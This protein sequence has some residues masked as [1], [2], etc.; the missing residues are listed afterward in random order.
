MRSIRVIACRLA[1]AVLLFATACSTDEGVGFNVKA[2]S[3]TG[4]FVS[5]ESDSFCILIDNKFIDDV[6]RC[7]GLTAGS[8]IPDDLA[9]GDRVIVEAVEGVIETVELD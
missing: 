9:V 2:E 1:S 3:M 8:E 4:S 7:F 5:Q 6:E